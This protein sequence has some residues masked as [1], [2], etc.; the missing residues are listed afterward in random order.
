MSHIISI[1]LIA[2]SLAFTSLA[3]TR[4]SFKSAKIPRHTEKLTAPIKIDVQL[5]GPAPEKPGDEYRLVGLIYSNRD[6]DQV[7]VEWKL[8]GKTDL[9]V[10]KVKE[11]LSVSANQVHRV[12]VTLRAKKPGPQRIRLRVSG[13]TKE[14]RFTASGLY[15]GEFAKGD[16]NKDSHFNA[17][18][19]DRL[20]PPD[21]KD[22]EEKKRQRI[23]Q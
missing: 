21:S 14:A 17:Q 3:E 13:G 20:V 9:I 22:G 12:E 15:R 8:G 4:S 5:E 16:S 18:S 23:F 19:P 1:S 6:F 7:D 2:L 10:G 11:T